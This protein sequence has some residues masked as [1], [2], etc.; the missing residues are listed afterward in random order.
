MVGGIPVLMASERV[1]S[2]RDRR[3]TTPRE[4][5]SVISSFDA[6]VPGSIVIPAAT[7]LDDGLCSLI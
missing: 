7:R 1:G 5:C 3:L 2:G 6:T 4:E